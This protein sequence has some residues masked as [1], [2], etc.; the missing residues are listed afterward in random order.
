MGILELVVC[1]RRTGKLEKPE[2]KPVSSTKAIVV[3]TSHRHH[4]KR[5]LLHHDQ[6]ADLPLAAPTATHP[7][8]KTED[9]DLKCRTPKR[10]H[11]RT[12]AKCR[13]ASGCTGCRLTAACSSDALPACLPTGGTTTTQ[14]DR[15]RTDSNARAKKPVTPVQHTTADT[16][17]HESIEAHRHDVL[18]FC[19]RCCCCFCR[20]CYATASETDR[21]RR[22]CGPGRILLLLLLLQMPEQT[23]GAAVADTSS[24]RRRVG[25]FL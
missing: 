3:T 18:D 5:Q 22:R 15:R 17:T 8:A 9:T 25:K 11:R 16:Y 6:A 23:N 1:F 2:R 12:T 19:C 10:Q 21:L 14:S 13:A 4:Q 20:C 24:G 7:E